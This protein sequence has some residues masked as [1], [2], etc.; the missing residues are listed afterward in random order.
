MVVMSHWSL[1]SSEKVTKESAS[2][3][4]TIKEA[5][6]GENYPSQLSSPKE[7]AS[8]LGGSKPS[9]R[10]GILNLCY[11]DLSILGLTDYCRKG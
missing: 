7:S 4:A 1:P 3:L 10:D 11:L 2:Q 6:T 8:Y 5:P 9:Y